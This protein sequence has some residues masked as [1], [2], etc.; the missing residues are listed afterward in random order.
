MDKFINANKIKEYHL[1]LETY[2]D[3]IPFLFYYYIDVS[4]RT[5]FLRKLNNYESIKKKMLEEKI[6]LNYTTNP[7]NFQVTL[8]KKWCDKNKK[9]QDILL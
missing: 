2:P 7:I 8:V 6:N 4:K 9:Y 1:D 5:S 3:Y